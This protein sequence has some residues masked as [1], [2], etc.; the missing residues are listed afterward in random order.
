[1]GLIRDYENMELPLEKRLPSLARRFTCLV[2]AAGL[3]PWNPE[4]LYS[5]TLSQGEGTAPWYAGHLI[6]NLSG[7]GPW[8]M[9]NAVEAVK[10]WNAED[11][12]IFASWARTWTGPS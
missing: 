12:A 2:D 10:V 6:L 1:M 8:K 4:Q 7:L 3:A 9:F 5:W 11:R